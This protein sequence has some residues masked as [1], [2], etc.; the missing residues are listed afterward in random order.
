MRRYCL[1][2]ALML[3]VMSVMGQSRLVPT[4][5]IEDA[6]GNDGYMMIV[7]DYLYGAAVF[8]WGIRLDG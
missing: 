4:A 8:H 1:F 6:S 2:L 7:K 3:A 5:K